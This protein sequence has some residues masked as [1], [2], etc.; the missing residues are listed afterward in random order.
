MIDE[1]Y[2]DDDY[3]DM[4]RPN[5]LFKNLDEVKLFCNGASKEDLKFF[6]VSCENEEEFEYCK[7]IQDL[8][9]TMK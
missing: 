7:Y 2:F 8:L 6:L 4:I 5:K 9:K 1:I 3:E